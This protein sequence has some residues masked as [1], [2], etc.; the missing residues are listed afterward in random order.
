MHYFF[1]QQSA[2]HIAY[3]CVWLP[4]A[5]VSEPL[6]VVCCIASH[7]IQSKGLRAD[8][9]AAR[10]KIPIDTWRSDVP[11]LSYV[12]VVRPHMGTTFHAYTRE[13]PIFVH[14]TAAQP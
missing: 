1:L 2:D 10:Q 12:L 3:F 5:Q 8:G 13:I 6:S 11:S 9:V 7:Y 4:S 14:K